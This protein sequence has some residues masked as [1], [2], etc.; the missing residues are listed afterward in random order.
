MLKEAYDQ[1]TASAYADFLFSKE[2]KLLP[3]VSVPKNP[4]PGEEA[5]KMLQ[6]IGERARIKKAPSPASHLGPKMSVDPDGTRVLN[7]GHTPPKP[8]NF[9]DKNIRDWAPPKLEKEGA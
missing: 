3:K 2:A 9:S 5:W 8:V 6:G 7:Y 1:G 4:Y